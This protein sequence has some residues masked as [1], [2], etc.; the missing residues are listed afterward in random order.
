LRDWSIARRHYRL[1]LADAIAAHDEALAYGGRSGV[2]SLHLIES[3]IFRP[4]S[5]Y[6]PRLWSKAAA[7]LESVVNNHGFVDGNKRTAWI[8]TELLVERSGYF[9]N[10]PDDE[11]IDDVVVDVAQGHMQFLDLEQWF[12]ERLARKTD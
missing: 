1:T 5:G 3:S 2:V 6:H 8:L 10:I 11:R 7:L 12:R 4:Y 9:L